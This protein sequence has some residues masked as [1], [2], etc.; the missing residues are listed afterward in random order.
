MVIL[1]DAGTMHGRSARRR[2]PSVPYPGAW[3]VLWQL[4]WST[5]CWEIACTVSLLTMA[6]YASM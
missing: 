1:L 4:P 5:R 6:F 3:T 2:M